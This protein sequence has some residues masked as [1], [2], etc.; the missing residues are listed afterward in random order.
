MAYG[1]RMTSGELLIEIKRSGGVLIFAGTIPAKRL[2]WSNAASMCASHILSDR[3]ISK[4][5]CRSFH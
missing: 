3:P 2:C 4:E 1:G 5:H